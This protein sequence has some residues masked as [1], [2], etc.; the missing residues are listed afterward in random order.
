MSVRLFDC[1]CRIGRRLDARPNEPSTV[2]ELLAE[3]DRLEIEKALVA[4]YSGYESLPDLGNRRI[5]DEARG[6]P[7][8]ARVWTAL[9]D[10]AGDTPPAKQWVAGMLSAGAR[11]VQLFP[12]RMNWRLDEWCAG[13]LLRAIE[14][15]KVLALLPF[16]EA[17]LGTIHEVLDAH[18]RLPLLLTNV[19]YRVNRM[20]FPLL[21]LHANLHIDLAP[22]YDVHDGVE[23]I[24]KRFG[25]KRL[26]FGT[27]YP[28][29]EP[30]AALAMLAYARIAD[31]ER[32]LIGAGNLERLLGEVQA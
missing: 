30:G 31:E 11:A 4:H 5:E 15:R 23:E 10:T 22:P 27:G 26:L 24:C 6:N 12:K 7:R 16:A 13:S 18:P 14:E 32:A 29:A 2:A 3:M 28:V 19:N 20:L 21:E 9:P 1:N 8:L 17:D 25:A